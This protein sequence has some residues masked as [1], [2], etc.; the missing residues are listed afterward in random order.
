MNRWVHPYPVWLRV[1]HWSN[2]LLFVVLLITGL[3]MHYSAPDRPTVG[4]RT[5]VLVHNT[6]GVLLTL[7]Y[8]VVLGG[9]VKLHPLVV[10][11]S[12]FGGGMLFGVVE[13]LLARPTITVFK[14]FVSN[15]AKP[16]NAYG[17]I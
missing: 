7:C 15:T 17:L 12:V 14:A 1:W 16:L 6:A 13:M 11:I 5:T 10:V 2:A 3:S 8:G 4:F 9:A